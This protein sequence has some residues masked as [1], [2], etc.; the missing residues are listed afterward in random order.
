MRVITILN[1]KIMDGPYTILSEDYTSGTTL[2]VEDSSGYS[3]NDLILVGSVGDEKA[4]TT[5]LTSAPPNSS[6]L[7]IS[8]LSFAHDA[9]EPIQKI[10][11]DQYEI[12]YKT[13]STGNW[14]NLVTGASFYWGKDK[15]EYVH[16]AGVSTYYYRSRYYN[17][18]TGTYSDYSDS[19]VGTGYNRLQV[20]WLIGRVR[21]KAQ[22]KNKEHASDKDIIASFN[23][24]NDIVRGLNRK[25][26]FLK[27]EDEINTI[28][29]Q[30]EYDL[31]DNFDRGYRLKFNRHSTEENVEYYLKYRSN[32]EFQYMYQDQEATSDDDL[33]DYTIDS[34]NEKLVLGPTPAT[35][36]YVLTL[37]YFKT[38]D[39]VETYGDTVPVPLADLYVHYAAAEIWETKDNEKKA[40]YHKAEFTSM[41]KVLEQMRAKNYEPKQMMAFKG[42]GAANRWYGSSRGT[43]DDERERYY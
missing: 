12:D 43:T 42:R 38:L 36:D 1:P 22:D 23:S 11:Y 3:D 40:Q 34:V 29:D 25:W 10:L 39:D 14:V 15:T 32:V 5:D 20:G 4:E 6:S 8:A 33:S 21:S 19:V 41:L 13:S 30:K 2:T 31:P 7:A 16:D 37:I 28:A 26:W 24:V 27:D 17:S 35:S 18:A 9:D